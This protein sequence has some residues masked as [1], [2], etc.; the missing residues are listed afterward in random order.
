MLHLHNADLLDSERLEAVSQVLKKRDFYGIETNKEIKN[1]FI[2]LGQA[3]GTFSNSLKKIHE[4]SS[5]FIAVLQKKKEKDTNQ[6]DYFLECFANVLSVIQHIYETNG[7]ISEKIEKTIVHKMEKEETERISEINTTYRDKEKKENYSINKQE[8]HVAHPEKKEEEVG[9]MELF[10][11]HIP[12]QTIESDFQQF[13]RSPNY[14]KKYAND[15][16]YRKT[17]AQLNDLEIKL[18][19]EIK[20]VTEL[21]QK[22]GK[23]TSTL[24]LN[25]SNERINNIH[26]ERKSHLEFLYS[27]IK[28][29][30]DRKQFFQNQY[31]TTQTLT[32]NSKQQHIKETKQNLTNSEVKETQRNTNH[33][34]PDNYLENFEKREKKRIEQI[35]DSFRMLL[36]TLH[37]N[38]SD[39]NNKV[40]M[41]ANQLNTYDSIKD[42]QKWL[43]V[44]LEKEVDLN[45]LQKKTHNKSLRPHED[46][47]ILIMLPKTNSD[48]SLVPKKEVST[49]K[50]KE[51]TETKKH[52]SNGKIQKIPQTTHIKQ[53]IEKTPK[54]MAQELKILNDAQKEKNKG[55][56][57]RNTQDFLDGSRKKHQLQ[58][59]V[60][61]ESGKKQK[62]H[63]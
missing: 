40:R 19:R 46:K 13:M 20:A 30:I 38:N 63:F 43:S 54:E 44:L 48:L 61:I 49:E 8:Q 39:L 52:L 4:D 11:E 31:T 25:K 12:L 26:Q 55:D 21:K 6:Q 56:I 37:R 41:F 23:N 62:P 15:K 9:I 47:H 59:V 34:Y 17:F 33:W 27:N 51:P 50:E 1:I 24:L 60:E 3:Y 36:M 53:T 22:F 58:Q 14:S 18:K 42:Y 10:I 5:R 32:K 29:L 45:V 16:K 57:N 7:V 35:Y 28:D 2:H